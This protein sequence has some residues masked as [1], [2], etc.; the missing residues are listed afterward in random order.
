MAKYD[1]RCNDLNNQAASLQSI[2]KALASYEKRLESI[3]NEMD[4]RDSSMANLK[5]QVKNCSKAISTVSKKGSCASNALLEVIEIYRSAEREN[6]FG[7]QGMCPPVYGVDLSEKQAIAKAINEGSI[8]LSS[9][10]REMISKL[11]KD[12]AK[13]LFDVL[14]EIEKEK[15][16]SGGAFEVIAGIYS[17]LSNFRKE[18]YYHGLL[19]FLKTAGKTVI[20]IKF[21]EDKIAGIKGSTAV[22]YAIDF[23]KNTYDNFYT[24]DN[25]TSRAILETIGE[26]AVLVGTTYFSATAASYLVGMT[27]LATVGA[28]AIITAAAAG[29]AAYAAKKAWIGL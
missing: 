25:T 13:T 27:G 15:K 28:P 11:I 4:A 24:E 26:G 7:F 9:S 18:K 21:P 14:K 12:P 23:F 16:G 2:S 1:V 19:D 3:A 22:S 5:A 20:S 6:Y 8:I 10:D 29:F 17:G